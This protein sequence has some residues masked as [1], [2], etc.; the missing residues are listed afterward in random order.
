MVETV[1]CLDREATISA[2]GQYPASRPIEFKKEQPDPR[3]VS[4]V[5]QGGRGF[6]GWTWGNLM[7]PVLSWLLLRRQLPSVEGRETPA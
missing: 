5:S 3:K 1:Q 4:A 6:A 7:R 2:T